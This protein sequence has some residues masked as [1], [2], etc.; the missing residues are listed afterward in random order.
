MSELTASIAR[1]LLSSMPTMGVFSLRIL[2]VMTVARLWVSILLPVSSSTDEKEEAQ[3]RKE[4]SIS[5]ESRWLF[6]SRQ[7]VRCKTR[8]RFSSSAISKK[9]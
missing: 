7:H 4:K 2:G 3:I 9:Q 6:G 8:L 5:R 1:K